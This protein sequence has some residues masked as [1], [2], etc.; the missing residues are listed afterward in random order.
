MSAILNLKKAGLSKVSK[1]AQN[2]LCMVLWITASENRH[3]RSNQCGIS[4]DFL[5]LKMQNGMLAETTGTASPSSLIKISKYTEWASFKD[6][7]MTVH[8]NSQLLINM[9]SEKLTI[10]LF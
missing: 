10:L 2:L 7:R 3:N 4:K 5:T 8:N 9:S 1:M 6:I